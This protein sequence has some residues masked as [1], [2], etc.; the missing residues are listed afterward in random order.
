MKKTKIVVVICSII[1]VLLCLIPI[2]LKL[3]DGGTTHL[4]PIV[5]MY[6]IYI[7]NTGMPDENDGTIY[8]KGYGIYLLGIE[9]CENVYYVNE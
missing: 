2:P 8:K 1:A 9:I 7:Y 5:P 3:K 4:K 6:E